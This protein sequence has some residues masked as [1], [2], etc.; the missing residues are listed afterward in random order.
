MY[1]FWKSFWLLADPKFWIASTV[2]MLVGTALAYGMTGKFDLYWFIVSIIG[3][4]CIEIGKMAVNDLVDFYTGVDFAVL[5]QNIT[6]FSGGR[7][8]VL[9]KGQ[10]QPTHAV[11]IAIVMLSL[12][13]LFGIYIT[14]F[15]EPQIFWIG[16]L[17]LFLAVAYSLPPFKF[18]YRGLGEI[19]VGIAFG[20]LIVSGAFVIQTHFL[21]GDV[22]LVSLP[23]GFLVTNILFINQYP[24]Y[25]ADKQCNKRNWVVRLGKR[26][27][28]KLYITLFALTYLSILIIFYTTKNPFWL[29]SFFSLPTVIQAV[30]VAAIA[31]DDIPTLV[32]A[33][34]NTIWAYQINGLA[35]LLSAIIK[36]FL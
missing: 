30:R 26:K 8:R 33:N 1:Q 19:V 28:F 7:N 29:L 25:E 15:R 21:T 3:L 24:D 14:F 10:L 23:I 11:L 9:V 4:Y 17:G 34:L 32:S 20:P 6:P 22:F 2:P 31:M 18:A 36:R 13:G 5:P 16:T 27:G 12:G 35:M